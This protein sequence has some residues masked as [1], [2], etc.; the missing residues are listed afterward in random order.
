MEKKR[1]AFAGSWY[2]EDAQECKEILINGFN[3]YT[4]LVLQKIASILG[5]NPIQ[6]ILKDIE[7]IIGYV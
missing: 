7:N 4:T 3:E 6:T 5:M 1:A 2:P